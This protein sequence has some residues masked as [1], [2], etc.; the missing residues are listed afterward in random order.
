VR[1][2]ARIDP[3]V[4]I[5]FDDNVDHGRL[6]TT[7]SGPHW[8]QMIDSLDQ[9]AMVMEMA[10]GWGSRDFFLGKVCDIIVL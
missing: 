1:S 9:F 10:W 6:R 7:G 3:W 2:L 4:Q 5:D 8:P